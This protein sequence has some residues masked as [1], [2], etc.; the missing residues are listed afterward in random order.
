MRNFFSIPSLGR[1]PQAPNCRIWVIMTEGIGRVKRGIRSSLLDGVKKRQ[2]INGAFFT[3][4][5]KILEVP[6]SQKMEI[7]II[8]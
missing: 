8:F 2:L 1:K 7:K 3:T 4:D 6:A 5:Y